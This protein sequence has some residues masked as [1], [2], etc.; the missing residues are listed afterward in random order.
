LRKWVVNASPLIT[1]AKIG[2]G[3]LLF[4]L[5]DELVIP[6]GVAEEIDRSPEEN[7]PAKVWIRSHGM[8]YVRNAGPV[9]PVIA[10]WD[11]GLGESQVLAWASGHTGYEA[12][13]DDRAARNCALSLGIKVCG[14]IGIIIL[15]KREQK[16]MSAASVLDLLQ[17]AGFRIDPVLIHKAKRLAGEG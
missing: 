4:Q 13:L 6:E 9:P 8:E 1:L 12:I 2:Q 3:S 14:T 5:C 17:Q 10:G 15:A 7:D 11:L 16:I